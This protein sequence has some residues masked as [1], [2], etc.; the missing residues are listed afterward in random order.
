MNNLVLLT[1]D[2]LIDMFLAFRAN[3]IQ[4]S[5]CEIDCDAEMYA[6]VREYYRGM[7][8]LR[9]Y[10]NNE[11][12]DE[13]LFAVCLSKG[14]YLYIQSNEDKSSVVITFD[15][16]KNA[17]HLMKSEKIYQD[18]YV[19]LRNGLFSDKEIGILYSLICNFALNYKKY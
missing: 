13:V 19:L 14:G 1:E 16:V 11:I 9:A 7:A 17:L 18:D 12:T 4:V 15:D 10:R 8:L 5:L 2:S 3:G 6:D